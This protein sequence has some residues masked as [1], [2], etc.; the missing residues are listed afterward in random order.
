MSLTQLIL[1]SD[2]LKTQQFA[3]FNEEEDRILAGK[4]DRFIFRVV[5]MA[6]D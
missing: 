3:G 4:G 2:S 6:Q 5:G 1:D